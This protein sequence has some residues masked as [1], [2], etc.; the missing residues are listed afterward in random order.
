IF[1]LRRPRRA[2]RPAVDSRRQNP[3]EEATIKAW[4]TSLAGPGTSSRIE[5]H[6]STIAQLSETGW[7]FSDMNVA[8]KC[9]SD[10]GNLFPPLRLNL[11]VDVHQR[12]GGWR[13]TRDSGGMAQRAR[14]DFGQ[15]FLHL[16]RE[17]A[18]RAVVEPFGNVALLSFL[19]PVDGA[20]LL[21]KIAFVF[22]LRFDGL[23]FVADGR[24]KYVV[25]RASCVV[26]NISVVGR[27]SLIVARSGR[28]RV[29]SC[30]I[31]FIG[32]VGFSRRGLK[33]IRSDI[34][35][36]RNQMFNRDLGPLEKL[37]ERL[38]ERRREVDFG[39]DLSG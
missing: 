24:G 9:R 8:T 12:N 1:F 21:L 18:H 17:P 2:H 38:A 34:S 26:R 36:D 4:I 14:T 30:R 7:P 16:A 23:E 32:I 39:P 6:A 31:E 28:A 20:L 22:D 27:R 11:D 35:E 3:D 5:Q 19:Q 29:Y 37:S 15:L 25:R 10:C 33:K 13:N